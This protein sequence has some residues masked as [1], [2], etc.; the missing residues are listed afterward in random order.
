MRLASLA[1]IGAFFCAFPLKAQTNGTTLPRETGGTVNTA[2]ADPD[3]NLCT[4]VVPLPGCPVSFIENTTDSGAKR[5]PPPRGGISRWDAWLL[6]HGFEPHFFVKTEATGAVLDCKGPSQVDA[7]NLFESNLTID[8]GKVLGWKATKIFASMH[9]YAGGNG[10]AEIVE[11]AQGYSNIDANPGTRMFELWVEKS[12]LSGKL[13]L[14]AGQMDANTDFAY[15]ENA[16]GFLN[17]S[18][19][20]SPSITEMPTYPLTR[21]GGAIFIVPRKFLYLSQGLF[22][23]EPH[24]AMSISEGGLRWQ[25][26]S[27]EMHGRVA[28]GFWKQTQQFCDDQGMLHRGANGTY[29]VA[30]QEIFRQRSVVDSGSRGLAAFFQYGTADPWSDEMDHHVGGG[31]QW[32]GPLASRPSDLIGLGASE[33]HLRPDSTETT[34]HEMA[35]EAFYRVQLK[36]FL[37]VTADLQLIDQP[38]GDVMCSRAVA[39]TLRTTISF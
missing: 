9:N 2:G 1:A 25:I 6:D 22:R 37:S 21:A 26:L 31:L 36:R 13:R 19:G 29:L 38:S 20:Y 8:L 14:K 4:G 35:Y 33:V 32:T 16:S 7:R 28:I 11:D 15:V 27:Q 30:E 12:V 5:V 18:M 17:S 3:L 34:N 39:G 10:S 24:G 23:N